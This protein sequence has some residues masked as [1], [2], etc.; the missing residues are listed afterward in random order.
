MGF[1]CGMLSRNVGSLAFRRCFSTVELYRGFWR[2]TI[3]PNMAPLLFHDC[4]K[5]GIKY[6]HAAVPTMLILQDPRELS[7]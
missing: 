4:W 3:I 6:L 5:E 7:F 2:T 1:Q